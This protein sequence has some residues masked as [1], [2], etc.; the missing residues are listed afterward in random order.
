[1]HT[2]IV[3][4]YHR[5]RFFCRTHDSVWRFYYR[6]HDSVWRFYYRTHDSVWRFYYRT[7]DSVWRRGPICVGNV[8]SVSVPL[9]RL[10]PRM[11]LCARMDTQNGRVRAP[12]CLCADVYSWP[13]RCNP[14][15]LKSITTN[16]VHVYSPYLRWVSSNV[17]WWTNC[18]LFYVVI[19]RNKLFYLLFCLRIKC[20]RLSI[21]GPTADKR[22]LTILCWKLINTH[23]KSVKD[24]HF[25]Y[26]SKR[27]HSCVM[28][29]NISYLLKMRLFWANTS[30]MLPWQPYYGGTHIH[31]ML[32]LP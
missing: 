20:L 7:H 3:I 5:F 1:M 32:E 18:I 29:S 16:W 17:I 14:T 26:H 9:I 2:V 6:T 31:K 21:Y 28:H 24:H 10:F 13:R 25:Y 30:W 22:G 23:L 15:L 12:I 11:S 8:P 4:Y 19:C 27:V